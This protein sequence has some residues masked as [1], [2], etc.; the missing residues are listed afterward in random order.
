M[1]S[2]RTG[3]LGAASALGVVVVTSFARAEVPTPADF[4]ECNVK[5]AD[6]AG[7]TASASPGPSPR[8]G[9]QPPGSPSDTASATAPR[10]RGPD[11]AADAGITGAKDPQIEGLAADRVSDPEYVAAYRS[12]MRQRGF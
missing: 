3:F 8:G 11:G 9:T 1:Q 10:P 5:A 7:D 12:C 4:A 6:A 2:A